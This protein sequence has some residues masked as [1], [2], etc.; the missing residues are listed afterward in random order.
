MEKKIKVYRVN[1]L[2]SE[3]DAISLVEYPAIESDF[4]YLAKERQNLSV[5]EEKRLLYGPVLI[6]DK[7][8]YR[9][10]EYTGEEYY[11]EFSAKAIEQLSRDFMEK[12]RNRNWTTDHEESTDRLSV[13]ETW[14]KSSEL[15]KSVSL[16]FELPDGTWFVGVYVDSNEIWEKVKSGEFRGFSIEAFL[17]LDEINQFRNMKMN[18]FFAKFKEFLNDYLSSTDMQAEEPKNEEEVKEEEGVEEKVEETLEETPETPEEEPSVEEE[19]KEEEP[20]PEPEVD[21]E[22]E[23]L[24]ATIKELE[25]KIEELQQK[26]EKLSKAPSAEPVNVKAESRDAREMLRMIAERF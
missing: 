12:M 4:I 7:P 3:V 20:A 25:Q 8:I 14:L 15:D 22:K 17:S 1:G 18:E 21:N 10:N 5:K 11:I 13:V 6:P 24:E 23:K 16:G 9:V 19:E 26:N 2:D